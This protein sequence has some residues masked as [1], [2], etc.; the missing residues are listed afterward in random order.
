MVPEQRTNPVPVASVCVVVPARASV[1][2][3][4]TSPPA[5]PTELCQCWPEPWGVLAWVSEI[6]SKVS[7]TGG[8]NQ[9]N[10]GGLKMMV[11]RDRAM[12]KN[13]NRVSTLKLLRAQCLSV[14]PSSWG[15]R[16]QQLPHRPEGQN[17]SVL[18][19]SWLAIW[20][21]GNHLGFLALSLPLAFN[22]LDCELLGAENVTGCIYSGHRF[23]GASLSVINNGDF[24]RIFFIWV[25]KKWS[26]I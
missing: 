22:H 5:E 8:K 6:W 15:D 4:P 9:G 14:V 12:G 10:Q 3:E 25:G 19:C 7:D 18:L 23:T 17:T 16:I 21:Q 11:A 24:T 20:P 1:T 13:S 26:V 2:A